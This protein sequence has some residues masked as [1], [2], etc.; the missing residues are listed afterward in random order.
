MSRLMGPGK[1][2]PQDLTGFPLPFFLLTNG[3]QIHYRAPDFVLSKFWGIV[4]SIDRFRHMPFGSE[5]AAVAPPATPAP[6][7]GQAAGA[8]SGSLGNGSS[9]RPRHTPVAGRLMATPL[10]GEQ[11][12]GLWWRPCRLWRSHQARPVEPYLM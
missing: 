10:W 3:P 2:E 12:L 5:P 1:I 8:P 7:D 6:S 4:P 11:R 9:S